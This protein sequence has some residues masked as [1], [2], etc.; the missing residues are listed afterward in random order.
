MT[1]KV[2]FGGKPLIP[3][4]YLEAADLNGRRVTVVIEK[5][6][7][8][9][10]IRG[11]GNKKDRKPVFYL[12][13]KEKGWVL[14]TTNLNRIAE[15]HG[16][17]AE[18]WI[19]KPVVLYAER[20]ESFGSMVPAVRVD[21]DA[22]REAADGQA[23]SSRANGNGKSAR[24]APE[25]SRRPQSAQAAP[26]QSMDFSADE[27]AGVGGPGLSEEQRGAFAGGDDE[28]AALKARLAALE[29]EPAHDANGVVLEESEAGARG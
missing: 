13:G 21:V 9:V 1:E 29:G 26:P 17:R 27:Y 3:S 4:K 28:V 15:V 10:E 6:E 2:S 5:I 16:K 8:N 25:Q 19:G 18:E 12:R 23:S 24:P 22:T 20:V 7:R 14:N 11:T